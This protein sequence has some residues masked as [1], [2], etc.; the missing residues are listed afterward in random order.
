ML[1]YQFG[2]PQLERPLGDQTDEDNTPQY[3]D[4]HNE[5]TIWENI[6][7]TED[8]GGRTKPMEIIVAWTVSGLRGLLWEPTQIHI[9]IAHLWDGDFDY[10]IM[11]TKRMFFNQVVELH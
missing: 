8:H 2:P 6:T 1:Q 3:G 11:T 7:Q 9:L 5:G 4:K 10:D